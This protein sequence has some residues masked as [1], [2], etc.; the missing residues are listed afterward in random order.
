MDLATFRRMINNAFIFKA[1]VE[2]YKDKRLTTQST[3][4]KIYVPQ[5]TDFFNR[6]LSET[7]EL[8]LTADMCRCNYLYFSSNPESEDPLQYTY[9]AAFDVFSGD[10]IVDNDTIIHSILEYYAETP[11]ETIAIKS[12]SPDNNDNG[13]VGFSCLHLLF[14]Q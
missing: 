13:H 2:H 6:E 10:S 4:T 5:Q 12:Q 14:K 8:F 7:S 9:R 3:R 11:L 1:T